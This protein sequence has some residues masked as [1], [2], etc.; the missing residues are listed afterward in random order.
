MEQS[1]LLNMITKRQH[2]TITFFPTEFIKKDK[3]FKV[4]ERNVIPWSLK[5]EIEDGFTREKALE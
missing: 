2:Y 4:Y 1:G 5:C 3:V